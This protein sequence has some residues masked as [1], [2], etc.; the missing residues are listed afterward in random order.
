MIAVLRASFAPS[1]A[2]IAS[3]SSLIAVTIDCNEPLTEPAG[4]AN[5][6]VPTIPW[7]ENPTKEAP[8]PAVLSPKS[9]I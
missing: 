2:S 9:A 7:P 6:S 5:K 3:L 1:N 8:L 4:N